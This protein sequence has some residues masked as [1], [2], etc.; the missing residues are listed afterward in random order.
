MTQFESI[1][2]RH[3]HVTFP[4]WTGERIYM[5]PFQVGDDLGKYTRTVNMMLDQIDTNDEMCFLMIDEAFVKAGTPHR[6]PGKHIEGWWDAG[7]SLHNGDG[8]GRWRLPG[9]VTEPV[10]RIPSRHSHKLDREEGI[11]LASNITACVG[12][13]GIF[14]GDLGKGGDCDHID[15][16]NMKTVNMEA[17][18]VWAGNVSM[19]HESTPVAFDCFRTVVRINVPHWRPN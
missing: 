15:T 8:S 7:M 2:Q 10:H 17:H 11:I 19:L 6:R 16:S 18:N 9:H 4:D 14:E 13:E 3:G 5:K 12:Y 1:I